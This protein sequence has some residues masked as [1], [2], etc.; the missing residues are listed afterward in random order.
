MMRG[1]RGLSE[2]VARAPV[3]LS[4]IGNVERGGGTPRWFAMLLSSSVLSK[5]VWW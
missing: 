2:G 5:M 4:N 1:M 3:R